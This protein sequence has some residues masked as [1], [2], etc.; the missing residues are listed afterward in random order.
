MSREL[1]EKTPDALYSSVR[2]PV[3]VHWASKGGRVEMEFENDEQ[4]LR[5]IDVLDNL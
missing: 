3:K 4:L 2:L 5:V 1:K